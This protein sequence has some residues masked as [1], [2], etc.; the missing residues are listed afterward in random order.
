MIRVKTIMV[1]V[2]FSEA[3][4]K[5]VNYGLSLALEFESRLLLAHIAPY[6][7][8]AYDSAKRLLLDLIPK[9]YR[10]GLDYEIIVKAGEVRQELLGIVEDRDVGLVVMG[11][12][13]RSY[14]ERLILGSVTERM[15]R[16]LHVPILT[17]SH[18]DPEKEILTPGPVPLRRI[19]YATDLAEGTE[20]GLEFS[21]RLARGLD[22]QLTV[23][24]VVQA[25]DAAFYGPETAAF[26][27]EYAEEVR[28]R[29]GE[30]LNQLVALVSD[31]GVPI[32]TVLADGVPYESINRVAEENEADLIVINLQAKG[33][34]E[35]ALLGTTAER[36]IRTANVPVLSLPLPATYAAG[37]A[38]A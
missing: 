14:F 22:A 20:A 16:K 29:A 17:V 8:Q 26:L 23:V 4:K 12:R 21:I 5:A 2:D 37:W 31:G 18:L 10:E 9:E 13:G 35:R 33:R 32:S 34:L 25:M 24:H 36:V 38:A 27:P 3:S 19:V 1:P 28:A 30:R 15:L 7:P 6:D 11:S